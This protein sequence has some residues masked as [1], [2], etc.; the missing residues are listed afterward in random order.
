[1]NKRN[2]WR[3]LDRMDSF[4]GP[5]ICM[6]VGSK[7]WYSKMLIWWAALW[8][9]YASEISR[10]DSPNFLIYGLQ[11][12]QLSSFNIRKDELPIYRITCSW[13][14]FGDVQS[15]LWPIRFMVGTWD[16]G[17]RTH[18]QTSAR[19]VIISNDMYGFTQ[20]VF[21]RTGSLE[22]VLNECIN[23]WLLIIKTSTKVSVALLI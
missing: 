14:F 8:I 2:E 3:V 4:L 18:V 20:F 7:F 17:P 6:C 15:T 16:C 22:W 21:E 9:Y 13:L 10:Y 12:L 23:H 5:N 1:M 19:L 11:V